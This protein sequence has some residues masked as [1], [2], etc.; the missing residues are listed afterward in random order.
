MLFSSSCVST[1]YEQS[2]ID[3]RIGDESTPSRSLG[4]T[5]ASATTAANT[6]RA[7]QLPIRFYSNGFTIG[8]GELRSFEENKDFMDHIKRGEVPPEL[9]NL[10]AGGKQI[11]VS[12]IKTRNHVRQYA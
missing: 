5:T 4:Q 12:T 9:R 1:S 10:G 8:E 11:E 6:N 7:E 3:T 2:I